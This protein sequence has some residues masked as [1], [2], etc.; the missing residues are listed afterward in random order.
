MLRWGCSGIRL[1]ALARQGS[2]VRAK[3]LSRSGVKAEAIGSGQTSGSR[4]RISGARVRGEGPMGP[5]ESKFL[6][7]ARALKAT[8][9]E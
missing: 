7:L 1:L 5:C 8:P 6:Q 4:S 9:P 2:G 3:A